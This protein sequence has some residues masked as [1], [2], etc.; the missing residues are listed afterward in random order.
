MHW[1]PRVLFLAFMLQFG[2]HFMPRTVSVG[3]IGSQ[4]AR[5]PAE[6][7]YEFYSGWVSFHQDV[8]LLSRRIERSPRLPHLPLGSLIAPSMSP[9]AGPLCVVSAAA[10]QGPQHDRE[11][12]R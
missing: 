2:D 7:S 4:L 1:I 12:D 9:D 11:Q 5:V 3:D 6:V 8:D 10:K